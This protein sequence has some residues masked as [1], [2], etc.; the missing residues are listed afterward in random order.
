M[1]K[2]AWTGI[3]LIVIG[4]ALGSVVAFGAYQAE[5]ATRAQRTPEALSP[6]SPPAPIK[7][8]AEAGD[9]TRGAPLYDH[10]CAGCHGTLGNS[11]RPLHG[12]LLNVYYPDDGVLAAIVRQGYGTM[13]P[14]DQH[15]L[16]DQD[17]MDVIAFIRTFP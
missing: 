11:D 1:S 13:P 14:T 2:V 4:L 7:L 9:P 6:L 10:T 8:Q 16:S 12:P 15:D 3:F 17:V 5:A